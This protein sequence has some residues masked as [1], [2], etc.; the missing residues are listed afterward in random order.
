MNTNYITLPEENKLRIANKDFDIAGVIK[1]EKEN[2]VIPVVKME[3]ISDLEWHKGCLKSRE[4]SPE[5]Y[6]SE[7]IEAVKESLRLH[8]AEIEA[9]EKEGLVFA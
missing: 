3:I 4:E 1:L 8:I 6:Q 2:A 7:D 9:R 5:L